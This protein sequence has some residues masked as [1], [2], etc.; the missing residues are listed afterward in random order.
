M[1]IRPDLK[2]RR[3]G[4]SYMLVAVSDGDLNTTAVHTFNATA[5]FIWTA[6][7]DAG[8]TDAE[9]LARLVCD[10]YDVDYAT[11]LADVRAILADWQAAGLIG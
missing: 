6:A 11:A 9:A 7:A 10:E 1:Q 2:L 3:V 8:G 4:D 5:A